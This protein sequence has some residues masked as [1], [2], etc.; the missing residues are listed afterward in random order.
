MVACISVSDHAHVINLL[1]NIVELHKGSLSMHLLQD[2]LL[3]Y[4]LSLP[5][6]VVE[7][8]NLA[9]DR[10]ITSGRYEK[11]FVLPCP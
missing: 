7:E 1:R 6:S 4:E 10:S 5:V 11:R 8:E 3:T 9:S 2:G